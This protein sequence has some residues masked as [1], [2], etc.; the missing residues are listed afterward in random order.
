[1][2]PISPKV[3]RANIFHL[4]AELLWM[5]VAFAIEWYYLQ[6]YAIRLD[7]TPTHLGIL[8]AGRALLMLV[9]A[10][11]TSRWLSRHTNIVRALSLPIIGYRTL[12]YL[13]VAFVPL[14]PAGRFRVDAL[15]GLVIIS[16]IPHGI[17]QGL[18][19]G[20]M[21]AAVSKASLGKVVARRSILINVAVLGCVFMFGG[22]LEWLPFP[23][24]YQVAFGMA[25]VTSMFGW[26]H[27]RRLKVPDVIQGKSEVVKDASF[28][29]WQYSPF[30]RFAALLIAVNLSVFLMAPLTQLHL[31]RG[32]SASDAWIAL[33]GIAEMTAGAVLTL[34]LDRLVRR[35]GTRKLIIATML[36]TALQPFI[37]ALTP[38]L[39]PFMIGSAAFGAGWFAINVLL[40][41]LMVE[42]V[43]SEHLTKFA[44]TYQMLINSCLFAGP[45]VGTFMIENIMT[46]PTA[47]L[48][49]ASLRFITSF[50]ARSIPNAPE[51]ETITPPIEPMESIHWETS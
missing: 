38:T 9:V 40:Y 45:L 4:Y 25:Y 13:C 50:L 10:A 30:K 21:P 43:P 27:I 3:E 18:F 24:N 16:A 33:F 36:A 48:L 23:V 37:L 49:I 6:V 42:I 20:M 44:A 15:V 31:V 14:L 28:R 41:N 35:F 2:H 12:I 19:L 22:L 8:T 34:R 32:L 39:W 26:L 29:V 5:S 7:A 17:A 11:L 1:M 47:L 46:I 51:P